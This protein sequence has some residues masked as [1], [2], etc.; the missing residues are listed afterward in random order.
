M[1]ASVASLAARQL[2][3]AVGL[4]AAS[5]LLAAQPQHAHGAPATE[6]LQVVAAQLVVLLAIVAGFRLNRQKAAQPR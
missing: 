5:P 3:A 2:A 6:S 1:S 4:L